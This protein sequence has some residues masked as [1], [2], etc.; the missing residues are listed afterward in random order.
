MCFRPLNVRGYRRVSGACTCT[1]AVTLDII[2][3]TGTY[4]T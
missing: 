1:T 2:N 3:A 4:A